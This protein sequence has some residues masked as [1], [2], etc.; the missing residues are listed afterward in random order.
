MHYDYTGFVINALV[1]YLILLL[2]VSGITAAVHGSR[3][4]RA[5][6][7]IDQYY[8]LLEQINEIE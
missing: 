6:K 4:D 2:V 8:D 1:G 7:R 3:Y 5:K